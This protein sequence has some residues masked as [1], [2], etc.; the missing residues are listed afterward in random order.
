MNCCEFQDSQSCY[1]ETL[2]QKKGGGGGRKE[3][4]KEGGEKKEEW[5]VLLKYQYYKE[6]VRNISL[7][8]KSMTTNSKK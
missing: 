4:R 8:K 7:L 3:G 6:K 5:P 2:S 1:R